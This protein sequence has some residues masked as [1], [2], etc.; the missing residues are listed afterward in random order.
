MDNNA[1]QRISGASALIGAAFLLIELPLYFVYSGP[2]P[3]GNIL[4]RSLFGLL[5]TTALIVFMTSLNH[6]IKRIGPAY[7]WV[8]SLATTAGSMWLTVVFVSTALEVGAVIQSPTDIDPTITVSGTYI[9]YGTVSRL[10]EALFFAAFGV[11]IGRTALLP[12]W[13]SRSAY[14]LAAINLAFVPSLYFGNTPANFYAANGWGT[15][16]TLGGFTMIWLL[17]IGVALLRATAAPPLSA[18]HP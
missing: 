7:E 15:T 4:T 5:G 6:L 12:R 16:A 13:A 10:L 2:P 14:A 3:D 8:G 17:F 18:A 1:I 9:L 11:A